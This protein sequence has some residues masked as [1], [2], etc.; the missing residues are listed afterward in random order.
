MTSR[1]SQDGGLRLVRELEHCPRSLVPTGPAQLDAQ[2]RADCEQSQSPLWWEQE[3]Y[4][5]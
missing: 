4:A 5:G 2:A 3:G 1:L